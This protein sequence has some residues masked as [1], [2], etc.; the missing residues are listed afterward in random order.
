MR[1]G[2]LKTWVLALT[3]LIVPSQAAAEIP[4]AVIADPPSDPAHIPRMI[5]APMPT[6]G[7][8]IP[9][10]FYTAADSGRHPTIVLFTGMPGAE[11]NSDL[12]YAIR[13]AGWNVVAFHYRGS[14]GSGGQFS[15]AN[16]IGDG[17]AAVAWLRNPGPDVAPFIDP[18]RIVVA[19]HSFGG[20][21]AGW[22]AAHDPKIMGAAMISAA[23]MTIPPDT[24]RGDLV[25][26]LD[27]WVHVGGMQL[28]NADAGNLADE[29]LRDGAGWDL[30]KQASA[31]AGRP[32]L[33]VTSNDG[34]APSDEA[35]A[36]AVTAAKA[37][38]KVT[39]IHFETNHGYND[40]RIALAGALVSWLE[41]ISR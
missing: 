6:G 35:I 5:V 31:L 8:A 34:L 28:L 40:K 2:V 18:E 12:I 9:A 29:A 13:R 11:M 21:L 30:T 14:W 10:M 15:V 17:A 19:G 1:C 37:D 39:K 20:W 36:V 38:A 22:T 3:C 24:P 23:D 26:Y 27:G 4:S 33:I 41:D 16:A 32:L 25:K 7:I